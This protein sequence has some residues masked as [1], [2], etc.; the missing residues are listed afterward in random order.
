MTTFSFP[1]S[2][3]NV[4]S[5]FSFLLSA[6]SAFSQLPAR[7]KLVVGVV[8]DQ[9]RYDQLYRYQKHFGQGGFNRLLRDGFSC[10]NTHYNYMPTNTGPGHAAIYTGTT[11]AINGIIGN[12]WWDNEW[13][14]DRY[15]TE[16][17]RYKTVGA[18]DGKSGRHSPSVLLS[19]TITDELRLSNNFRSKV[20]SVCLKDRGSI[21]PA[22]HIPNACYWF[23][24]ATGNWITSTYY[25]DSVALASWVQE[26]NKRRS[27]DTY[28][29]Q[30][31]TP[32]MPVTE[33]IENW[34]AF[35]SNKYG[36]VQGAF[37]HDLP[38]LRKSGSNYG[39]IRTTP[40]GNSFTLDLALEAV[41]RMGLGRDDDPDF[42]CISF[43]A[44]DYCGHQFGIHAAEMED[45]YVR[46]DADIERLLN[47]LD[48]K[49][50]PGNYI[51]FIT[52][53]SPQAFLRKARPRPCWKKCS[54]PSSAY[55]P[56]TCIRCKT[57]K[58][59]S[60]GKPLTPWKLIRTT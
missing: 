34:E 16:D 42:L 5:T 54:K 3:F 15:V 26:F 30:P 32:K 39:I 51:L 35:K 14:A 59:G 6:F 4:L 10:E 40:F 24:D 11:P 22:G 1:L 44:T 8:V 2:A 57:S 23:D 25:P 38:G 45:I 47:D 9:M 31:W 7:P 37:P 49:V 46:L 56:I 43:S 52:A 20:V 50:G 17:K 53:A 28:L 27:I 19:T 12:Y 36:D 55:R 13:H 33:S 21:L 58:S 48:K 18:P 29:S 41:D 60:I